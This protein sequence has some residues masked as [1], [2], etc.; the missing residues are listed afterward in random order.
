[1]N[2]RSEMGEALFQTLSDQDL[3]LTK[4][5]AEAE[6]RAALSKG[7]DDR[8]AV[9]QLATAPSSSAHVMYR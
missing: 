5:I 6:I 2:E 9:E 3:A 1:M 4:P 8:Q 7:A